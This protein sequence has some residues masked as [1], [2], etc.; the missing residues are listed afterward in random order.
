MA[1]H[2][3]DEVRLTGPADGLDGAERTGHQLV[4][5]T[6]LQLSSCTATHVGANVDPS[7]AKRDSEC[8]R[9]QCGRARGV[10]RRRAGTGGSQ[11]VLIICVVH[12]PTCLTR[13]VLRLL[14][15]YR[16]PGVGP[17]DSALLKLPGDSHAN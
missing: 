15:T 13:H 17:W 12:Y 8:L 11:P 16:I 5:P 3:V 10:T 14:S 2:R 9:K 6:L 1:G 7:V 4:S